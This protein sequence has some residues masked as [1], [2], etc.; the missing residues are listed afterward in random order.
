MPVAIKRPVRKW[1]TNRAFENLR[2]KNATEIFKTIHDD[3]AWSGVES[4]SG[5]GSDTAA[6]KTIASELPKLLQKYEISS[7]LDVPCGD[8]HWMQHVDMVGTQYVGADIVPALI[9]RN[10]QLYANDARKFKII[11]IINDT[12]PRTDLIF[13]RDCFIHLSEAHILRSLENFVH[14]GSK[15]LLMTTYPHKSYNWDCATGAY[16]PINFLK[17]PYC[18]PEPLETLLEDPPRPAEA[19]DP[20]FE[21]VM[22]LWTLESIRECLL[23]R[24]QP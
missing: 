23:A 6:T 20:N 10:T 13:C 2:R 14:S 11:D 19:G 18:L 15:F 22:G 17:A 1:F 16:R 8:F 9:N 24:N 21:R 7:I 3:N 5:P 4:L 12:I